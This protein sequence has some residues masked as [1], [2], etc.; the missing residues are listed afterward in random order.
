MPFVIDNQRQRMADVLNELLAGHAGR[1]L[2]VATAYF[3]V[4]GWELLAEGLRGLG[5]FRLLLGAEPETGAD[6]GLREARARAV[7]RLL[8][9]LAGEQF[10]E[11]NLRQVEDLIAYL[12]RESVQ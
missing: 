10:N 5:T 2:D 6:L 7:K 1:S 8:S 11:H 4:G 12:R 3:N 9:E